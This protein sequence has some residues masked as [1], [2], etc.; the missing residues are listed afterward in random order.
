MPVSLPVTL[1][2]RVSRAEPV[3]YQDA[4]GEAVLLDL[5]GERYYGLN[6]VGTR[7][8]QL[9]ERAPI[10]AD[11]HRE[12]CAEFEA[13]ETR[14]EHDMLTLIGDMQSAGLVVLE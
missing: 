13:E 14:I 5:N 2:H 1:A 10:L 12:L 7:I 4:G 8:W 6:N 11:M 3:M 9:L